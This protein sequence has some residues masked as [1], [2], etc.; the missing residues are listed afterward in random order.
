MGLAEPMSF[1]L[2]LDVGYGE[3]LLCER[4]NHHLRLAGRHNFVVEALEEDDGAGE[5]VSVVDG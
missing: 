3:A 5:L 1:A 4:V 2:E